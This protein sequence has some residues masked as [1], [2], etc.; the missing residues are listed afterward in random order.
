MLQQFKGRKSREGSCSFSWMRSGPVGGALCGPLASCI[1]A[2]LMFARPV[3]L[4]MPQWL[5]NVSILHPRK[6]AL[7]GP[8]LLFALGDFD[9]PL[10]IFS[11]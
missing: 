3:W 9:L 7:L 1:L 2:L 8:S 6:N 5:G 10:G 11:R 4:S